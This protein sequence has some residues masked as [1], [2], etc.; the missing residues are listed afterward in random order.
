MSR[1]EVT[2]VGVKDT[3]LDLVWLTDY[4]RHTEPHH[5]Y[6]TLGRDWRMASVEE[7]LTLPNRCS[8]LPTSAP[9]WL[10]DFAGKVWA[11]ECDRRDQ[12]KAWAV[13]M[14]TGEVSLRR[15]WRRLGALYVM[16]SQPDVSRWLPTTRVNLSKALEMPL[17]SYKEHEALAELGLLAPGQYWVEADAVTLAKGYGMTFACG[18]VYA[19]G[20]ASASLECLCI[21][22][23]K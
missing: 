18:A 19:G 2:A 8:A 1:F 10:G 20:R 11:A 6:A 12:N 7:L 4:V 13:D 15:R 9:P 14:R 23:E 16:K 3:R 21:T 17:K 22:E 5:E